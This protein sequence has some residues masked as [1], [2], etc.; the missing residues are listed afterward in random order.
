MKEEEGYQM[1]DEIIT[2]PKLINPH[3]E[4]VIVDSSGRKSRFVGAR[5]VGSLVLEGHSLER[6]IGAANALIRMAEATNRTELSTDAIR[7]FATE[8]LRG[9]PEEIAVRTLD[10]PIFRIEVSMKEPNF[11]IGDALVRLL[12]R[13][14]V[15][16]QNYPEFNASISQL[17][18]QAQEMLLASEQPTWKQ[19][20]T[21]TIAQ[22]KSRLEKVKEKLDAQ[23]A[24]DG[25]DAKRDLRDGLSTAAD[26][27]KNFPLAGGPRDGDMTANWFLEEYLIRVFQAE[28]TPP[29]A[30]DD[31]IIAVGER[32]YA[33]SDWKD[34][35]KYEHEFEQR[36]HTLKPPK[37]LARVAIRSGTQVYLGSKIVYEDDLFTPEEAKEWA[38]FWG[39]LFGALLDGAVEEGTKAVATLSNPGLPPNV[40]DRIVDILSKK[41]KEELKERAE[42]IKELT[43]QIVESWL[44]P[45]MFPPLPCMIVTDWQPGKEPAWSDPYQA[46]ILG[47]P[48]AGTGEG[49]IRFPVVPLDRDKGGKYRF[50]FQFRIVKE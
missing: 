22:A 41:A 38:Q 17:E 26:Y 19:D 1:P 35:P 40:W 15:D 14:V 27:Y 5:T 3:R 37:Q 34:Y 45:E 2:I 6:S 30:G 49:L 20:P 46:Q 42:K 43:E 21:G 32:I 12:P 29:T 48:A 44:G 11:G 39:L 50:N 33:N 8:W 28:E 7:H 23:S 10:A 25:D 18:E 16:S 4:L 24:A 9:T 47:R 31:D 36:R 13:M